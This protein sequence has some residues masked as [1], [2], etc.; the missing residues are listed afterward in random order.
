[1]AR[2]PKVSNTELTAI[3]CTADENIF[4]LRD[5]ARRASEKGVE[6][7]PTEP[8]I[9]ELMQFSASVMEL[10]TSLMY[11]RALMNVEA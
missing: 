4:L 11:R 9:L 2:T 5:L 7:M 8:Q 3:L 6:V 10:A 1:M